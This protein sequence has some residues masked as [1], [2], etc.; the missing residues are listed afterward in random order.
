MVRIMILRERSGKGLQLS[1]VGEPLH[2]AV[3][4]PLFH[5]SSGHLAQD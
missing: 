5:F 3:P 1:F 2:L 4:I